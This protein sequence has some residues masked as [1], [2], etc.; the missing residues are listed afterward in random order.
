VRGDERAARIN[1]QD[2]FQEVA[3]V[4]PQDGPAV[5]ADVADAFEPRLQPFQRGKG[6]HKDQVMDLADSVV[7]LVDVADLAAQQK[8][9]RPLTGRRHFGL[10]GGQQ[11]GLEAKQPLLGRFQLF[12]QFGQPARVGNV[13]RSDEMNALPLRPLGQPFQI[14][15]LA[16]GA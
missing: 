13:A 3:T 11:V 15:I 7:L 14:Q 5:G 10:N 1:L 4:Q 6:G 12:L 9:H 8:A 2:D 16:G